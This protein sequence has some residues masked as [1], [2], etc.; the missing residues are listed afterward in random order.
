M[1]NNYYFH[2]SNRVIF[3]LIFSLQWRS[4]WTP[5]VWLAV[6]KLAVTVFF[7]F[8]PCFPVTAF[9]NLPGAG[10]DTAAVQGSLLPSATSAQVQS[11]M[12]VLRH[13]LMRHNTSPS[14]KSCSLLVLGTSVETEILLQK[15]PQAIVRLFTGF[16]WLNK[17]IPF[18]LGA[19]SVIFN[20]NCW[21]VWFQHMFFFFLTACFANVNGKVINEQRANLSHCYCLLETNWICD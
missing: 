14:T 5:F 10:A 17:N 20:G 3:F 6:R 1:A 15:A 7:F 11:D 2:D 16:H 21:T 12:Y 19:Q 18:P 8:F 9:S 4:V 13:E